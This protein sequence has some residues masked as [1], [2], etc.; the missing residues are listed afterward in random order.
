[1][2]VVYNQQHK[3][4]RFNVC[5]LTKRRDVEGFLL[6]LTTEKYFKKFPRGGATELISS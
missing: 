3:H 5:N 1:M 6:I 4:C 2:T